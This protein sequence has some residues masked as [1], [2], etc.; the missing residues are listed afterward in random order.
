MPAAKFSLPMHIVDLWKTA[1]ELRI[2]AADEPADAAALRR[3]A[4][5]LEVQAGE[6]EES[7]S[8]AKPV[9]FV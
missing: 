8:R 9:G 7:Y 5:Q 4:D 6:L 1:A 3:M 2:A